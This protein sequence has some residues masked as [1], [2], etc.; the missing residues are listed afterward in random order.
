[1]VIR[2]KGKQYTDKKKG[3][4]FHIIHGSFVDGYGIRTTV[5]LKGCPLRC[6][7]CCNP[8]GQTGYP[9]LKYTIDKC[10]SCGKCLEI[11]P[12]GALTLD[13]ISEKILINRKLCTNCGKCISVCY[14]GALQYF[15]TYYT[16]DEVFNIIKKDEQYYRSS[17]GGATIGGGEPLFQASFTYA[18][19]KTCQENYIHVAIDTC[20]YAISKEQF[21]ILSEADLLLYDLKGLDTDVH[22]KNTG[23]SNEIIISNLKKLNDMGKS[24]IIRIPVIPRLTENEDNVED[25]AAMLAQLK[26]I[27]RVDLLPYHTYGTIKYQQLGREYNLDILCDVQALAEN[28]KR[29]LES[30]SLNVQLGG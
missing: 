10:N 18:L 11:C 12:E 15:G 9:E 2:D 30:Y 25:I 20:G 16:V 29:I 28:T 1:M 19:M 5:F 14:T 17:G 27:E 13:S 26:S 3:L 8:E 6:L 21:R 7:W 22:L 23:V 4:V 24:I